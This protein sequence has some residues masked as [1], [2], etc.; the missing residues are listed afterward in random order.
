M[1]L[2]LAESLRGGPFEEL[3]VRAS[4]GSSGPIVELSRE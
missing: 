2:S 1:E 3:L 4:A